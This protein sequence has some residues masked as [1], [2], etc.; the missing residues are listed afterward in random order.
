[1][2]HVMASHTSYIVIDLVQGAMEIPLGYLL[3]PVWI[4]HEA[5]G[6]K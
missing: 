5:Q 1:M 2:C 4:G 6:Y 3:S